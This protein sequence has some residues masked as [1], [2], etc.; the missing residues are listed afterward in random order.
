[1]AARSPV[2]YL[3][4]A[5]LDAD[6]SHTVIASCSHAL[7]GS[8]QKEYLG[9]LLKKRRG[10]IDGRMIRTRDDSVENIDFLL[11]ARFADAEFDADIAVGAIVSPQLAPTQAEA[12]CG[13]TIRG[14]RLKV[15]ARQALL[16][17]TGGLN[18][19][20]ITAFLDE[21][22]VKYSSDKFAQVQAHV[23]RVRVTMQD[24][25]RATFGRGDQLSVVA[26]DT[27]QL[28]IGS[29]EFKRTGV[30][31]RRYMC[32]Q[33]MKTTACVVAVCVVLIGIVVVVA[34]CASGE[35]CQGD[36]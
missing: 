4:V 13:D 12:L 3:C 19:R 9:A 6:G 28:M 10:L 8:S 5:R 21:L 2:S 25:I 34:V 23:D 14:F 36:S 24:N 32:F 11:C 18:Q 16:A 17:G 30:R 31:L 1:M 33:N 26:A 29:E 35:A 15:T 7:A 22:V 27:E 20:G